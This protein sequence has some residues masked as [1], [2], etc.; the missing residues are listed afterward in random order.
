M[1]KIDELGI[2]LSG[3]PIIRG[4]S[5]AVDAGETLCLLGPSGCGKST[6][7]RAIAGFEVPDYGTVEIEGRLVS[8]GRTLLPPQKRGVGM[9]F[10]DLALFPHLTIRANV[11][12]G[13]REM[14]K[15]EAAKRVDELLRQVRLHDHADKYPHMLSGGQQQR[16][17][18]ARA[19]AP[20]PRVMLLDEPFSGLDASLRTQ[21]RL[22]TIE[23]LKASSV[24]TLMVT[25]DPEEAM[26]TADRIALMHA[27]QIV[28]QGTP[29][30][31][32]DNPANAFAARF[33][34]EVNHVRGWV[35]DGAVQTC[36]GEFSESPF[37]DGTEVDVFIRPDA[38]SEAPNGT[39]QRY[40][41]RARVC[42]VQNA[43]GSRLVRLGF[44][45]QPQL[46]LVMRFPRS[47][48]AQVGDCVDLNIDRQQT[49]L[50]AK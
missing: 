21:V 46:H 10:Q 22:E 15:V 26:L 45:A 13:L 33:L 5:L 49:Y 16:V 35:R 25:H 17:A 12:Y 23:I 18:L 24:T 42:A 32:Y 3:T 19:L 38:M 14:S 11:A 6:T 7:L 28:Q 34:G 20:R 50:F 39:Q 1:V 9:L 48:S 29:E 30:E 43:G 4:V 31:I 47:F 44:G 36:F 27:G 40:L 8:G 37:E 41:A 2:S